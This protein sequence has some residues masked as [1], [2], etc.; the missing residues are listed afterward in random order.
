MS[1]NKKDVLFMKKVLSVLL[2]AVLICAG[3]SGC[4]G[5]NNELTE[6]NITQ[7]VNEA[8][9]ALQ[10]FDTEK[11]EKYVDSQTLSIIMGY[12]DKHEQFAELGR[13]IFKNLQVEIKEIDIENSTVTVSVLNKNLSETAEDFA[14]KLKDTY[15]TI[16][17]IKLLNDESF[18]DK[19]LSELC[20]QIEE[21]TMK[22]MPTDIELK[23]TQGKKNLVLT[24]DEDAENAVSGGAL[25]AIKRIYG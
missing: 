12:A 22:K 25:T 9:T 21:D 5:P 11:L 7:T 23:I 17:L 20:A 1:K 8:V 2:C 16:K 15:T 3:F 10:E 6:E 4:S 14:K 19:K 18:L 24:F 13:A